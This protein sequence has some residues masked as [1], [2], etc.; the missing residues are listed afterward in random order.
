MVRP[1]HPTDGVTLFHVSFLSLNDSQ[2]DLCLTA[3]LP[4][5]KRVL[6]MSILFLVC[7]ENGFAS[8]RLSYG[9]AFTYRPFPTYY[10]TVLVFVCLCVCTQLV[11]KSENIT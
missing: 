8:V 4:E 7:S 6:H 9:Q 1:Y 2:N 10:V 3:C 5:G 11:E